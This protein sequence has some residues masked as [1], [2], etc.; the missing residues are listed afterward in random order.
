MQYT[1]II[2]QH[3]PEIQ[4]GSNCRFH[5][6]LVQILLA[7]LEVLERHFTVCYLLSISSCTWAG[8]VTIVALFCAAWA[9]WSEDFIL[10]ASD[11]C[12]KAQDSGVKHLCYISLHS[13]VYSY[14]GQWGCSQLPSAITIFWNYYQLASFPCFTCQFILN[15]SQ[16]NPW[17]QIFVSET[18]CMNLNYRTNVLQIVQQTSWFEVQLNFWSDQ[19]MAYCRGSFRWPY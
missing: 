5:P 6:H 11:L 3:C 14:N 2:S 18:M 13:D 9:K 8:H 19:Y 15:I 12:Q 1:F 16:E 4:P 17:A 7:W 10:M